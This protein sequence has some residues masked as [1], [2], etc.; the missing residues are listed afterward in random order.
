M[1]CPSFEASFSLS[2][3]PG[4]A[5]EKDGYYVIKHGEELTLTF[6]NLTT[7]QNLYLAIFTFTEF[8]QVRNLVSEK[9]EDACMPVLP[10][11][12]EESDGREELSLMLE[13]PEELREKG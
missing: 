2:T 11:G 1:P 9:G 6:E 10:R 12:H 5:P 4:I 3:G 8:W 7:D 13:V